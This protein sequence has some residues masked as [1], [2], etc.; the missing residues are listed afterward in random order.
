MAPNPSAMDIGTA[1][2]AQANATPYSL[3]RQF[4]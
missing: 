4:S 2:L 1:M 3:L